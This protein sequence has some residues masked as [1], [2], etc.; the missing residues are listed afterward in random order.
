MFWTS[1]SSEHSIG[2]RI[3]MSWMDGTSRSLLASRDTHRDHVI[4]WPVSLT[5]HRGLNKLF[6]LDVLTQRINSMTLG[7]NRIISQ[8]YIETHSQSLTVVGNQIL[9]TDNI[10]NVLLI[11][12][13]DNNVN[14]TRR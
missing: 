12:D 5:Y 14:L 3:E 10:K 7:E 11:A 13:M 9:W 6:W 2:G 4:Y 8:I 1:F